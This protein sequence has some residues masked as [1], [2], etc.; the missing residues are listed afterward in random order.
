MLNSY[1]LFPVRRT[2][3]ARDR[4]KRYVEELVEL[5]VAALDDVVLDELP[6]SPL[7]LADPVSPPVLGEADAPSDDDEFA[8]FSR[9][10]FLV[11]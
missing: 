3:S 2:P 6:E 10:R 5:P 1:N 9:L 4:G 11:P 8:A 7:V